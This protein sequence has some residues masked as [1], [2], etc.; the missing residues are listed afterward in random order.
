MRSKKPSIPYLLERLSV[1]VVSGLATW[2]NPSK[3][4]PGLVGK[5]AGCPENS[6][7]KDYWVIRIDRKGY[8]R[9]QIIFAV[10]NNRWSDM[11][12]DHKDGDSMNDRLDNLRECT[13]LQNM[14][15]IRRMKKKSDL[16][17]GV[18]KYGERRYQARLTVNK[19]LIHLGIFDSSEAASAAYRAARKFHRGDFA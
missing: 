8:T 4:H 14:G 3:Y 7:G 2:I 5:N 1:D 12:I 15:N 17:M 6:N 16:P 19:K 10:A 11:E 18:K 13:H 9:S